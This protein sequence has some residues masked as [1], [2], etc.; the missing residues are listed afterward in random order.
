MVNKTKKLLN[1]MKPRPQMVAPIGTEI[2]IPNHSGVSVHPEFKAAVGDIDLTA[3]VLKAGD[4][5]TG[6]LQIQEGT[7]GTMKLQSTASGSTNLLFASTDELIEYLEISPTGGKNEFHMHSRNFYLKSNTKDLLEIDDTTGDIDFKSNNLTSLGTGH[8]AFSD[9]VANEHID[10][11]NTSTAF[12]TTGTAQIGQATL[13][14]SVPT[15]HI[16]NNDTDMESGET[17]GII[18][19]EGNRNEK[20]GARISATASDDWV[21]AGTY[22]HPTKL[23]IGVQDSSSGDETLTPLLTFNHEENIPITFH[24]DVDMEGTVTFSGVILADTGLQQNGSWVIRSDNSFRAPQ[25]AD[26][27]AANNSIYYSTDASKLVFKDGG[28]TVNNLY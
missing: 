4:S 14:S 7:G 11:T 12:K 21:S 9:F 1:S 18:L 24:D 3:Y 19:F 16:K 22:R 28:G 10:W 17:A 26:A 23:T 25:L 8:D 2:I 15:L 20:I 5:M 27:A 6:D 13:L